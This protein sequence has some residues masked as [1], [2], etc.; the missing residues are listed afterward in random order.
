MLLISSGTLFGG[1][2]E[3]HKGIRRQYN[4]IEM[5]LENGHADVSIH[6]RED[7]NDDIFSDDP[8]WRARSLPG[9]AI[10]YQVKT[11][12]VSERE[13]L[14]RI[15]KDTRE[16]KDY[17]YG[18]KALRSADLK[19]EGARLMMNDY[20]TKLDSKTILTILSEPEEENHCFLLIAAIDKEHDVEA[21][22]RLKNSQI[23][24]QS[25]EKDATLREQFM[26]LANKF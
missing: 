16:K 18:I 7:G 21:F 25:I 17:V 9:G 5:E 14:L 6:V 4:I 13:I 11:K 10:R 26:S 3:Q 19:N 20:L 15:D 2:S 8:Y 1:D 22:E 24:Q 12:E 23:L